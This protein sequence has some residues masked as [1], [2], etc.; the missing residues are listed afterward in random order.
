MLI[1]VLISVEVLLHSSGCGQGIQTLL[2]SWEGRH[3]A[4]D[5]GVHRGCRKVLNNFM[6]GN[7]QRLLIL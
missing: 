3:K 6:L 5:E 1:L 7:F 2:H 4:S